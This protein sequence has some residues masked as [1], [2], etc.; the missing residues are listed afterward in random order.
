MNGDK[1]I[2]YDLSIL[3]TNKVSFYLALEQYLLSQIDEDIF[4]LWDISTSIVIG[5]NQVLEGEV[6]LDY[7][8]RSKVPIFRRP[9][10]GGAI[11]ADDGCFMYSFLTKQRNKDKVYALFLAK[12]KQI[13]SSLGLE[14]VF[15]GRN[16]LLFKGKKFSGTAV[17]QNASGT[18]LHGTFLYDTNI[19]N[20]V[21][22]LTVDKTKL[23]SK[24]IKSVEERVIN[25]ASYIKISKKELMAY[26]IANIGDSIAFLPSFIT[27][28]IKDQEA[29]YTS[30]SWLYG[31]NP[32]Y[33]LLKKN[34]FAW[35]SIEVYLLVKQ[36]LIIELNIRGDFFQK[37]SLETFCAAFQQVAFTS[38]AVLAVLNKNTVSNYIYEATNQEFI[39]LLFEEKST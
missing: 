4:F 17:F 9:S 38:T 27:E 14:I 15:S 10:G 20:L 13:L 2:V 25:L 39:D 7:A 5:R 11:Y 29:K 36:N 23:I 16:D 19:P 1:M 3:G 26:L 18:I 33:S 21:T 34:R 24:G 28:V 37:Q 12:I 31:K 8:K 35:G 30:P 22:A 6:N 32:E